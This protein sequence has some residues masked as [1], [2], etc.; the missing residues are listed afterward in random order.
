[1]LGIRKLFAVALL[2]VPPVAAPPPFTML[3]LGACAAIVI[4]SAASLSQ[5]EAGSQLAFYSQQLHMLAWTV[6]GLIFGSI[7]P[8]LLA[9]MMPHPVVATTVAATAGV[10]LTGALT[11][12]GY[13][14]TL[15]T[16]LTKAKDG[17]PKGCGDALM[18]FLGVVVLTFGFHIYGQRALLVRHAAEVIGCAALASLLSML[19]TAAAGRAVG[20]S[21]DL[22]LALASLSL[23]LARALS[24][25]RALFLSLWALSRSLCM[26]FFSLWP[27][28]LSIG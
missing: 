15:K 8:T 25:S 28:S 22:S 12:S 11:G 14:A 9:P 3:H 17:Q 18:S 6:G 16:Y 13:Y 24:L 5:A 4:L 20:L 26:V 10:A 19:V 21:P 27:L 2:P 23:D 7:P 1:M